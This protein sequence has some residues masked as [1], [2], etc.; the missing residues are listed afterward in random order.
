M[1]M[2]IPSVDLSDNNATIP[3]I[4]R[5]PDLYLA[6]YLRARGISLVGTEGPRNR[7]IFL[8]EDRRDIQ[9]HV[10]E[11]FN[12]GPVGALDFKNY[13]RELKSLLHGRSAFSRS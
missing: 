6:A 2:K 10:A 1:E 13:L 12:N 9:K 5:T 8:F 11:Y 3:K 7:V 4:Y